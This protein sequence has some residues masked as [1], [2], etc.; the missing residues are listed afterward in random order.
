MIGRRKSNP[1]A[2]SAPIVTKAMRVLKM[3][4]TSPSNPGISE[5]AAKLSLAKSTT[6][7][8]LAALEE[9]GWVLRDP[10]TRKYTAGHAV[11]EIADKAAV[12]IPLV[13]HARPFLEKLSRDLDEDVF[14]GIFAGHD[15]LILDQVESTKEL[16]ITA[17]PG[18][19]LSMFAGAA[20]KI[21]LA[22][23]D[24]ETQGKLLR[25]HHL[26]RFTSRSITDQTAYLSE[27]DRVRETGVALDVEEYISNVRAVAVPIFYGKKNRKRMVA[28]IW[29][30]GLDWHLSPGKMDRIKKLAIKTAEAVSK[31]VS[32]N[33]SEH[34][35][36]L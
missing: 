12:R 11:K 33:Y 2:Y 25:H 15:V 29:L 28:G 34:H 35:N 26:P 1:I 8:I 32:S 22:Y 7:G 4:V 6:H 13:A 24:S 3:I 31:A 20:G 17:K 5:I 21:F 10:I 18:T 36:N 16:R 27:L 30:V 9:S 14:V 19:R 23:L